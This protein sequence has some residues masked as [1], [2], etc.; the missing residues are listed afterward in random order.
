[1]LIGQFY[2]LIKAK[3]CSKTTISSDNIAQVRRWKGQRSFS[4]KPKYLTLFKPSV[5]EN[6]AK[7]VQRR[8]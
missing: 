6:G 7:I 3:K 4:H 5:I 2:M 8:A 1:M